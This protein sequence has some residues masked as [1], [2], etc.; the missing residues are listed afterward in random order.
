MFEIKQYKT[1]WD[2]QNP[3]KDEK[4]NR[5]DPGRIHVSHRWPWPS[6]LGSPTNFSDTAGNIQPVSGQIRDGVWNY[7]LVICYIAMENRWPIEIDGYLLKAWWIFPW[8]YQWPGTSDLCF[9]TSK[10]DAVRAN[11]H[12]TVLVCL[13]KR[14]PIFKDWIAKKSNI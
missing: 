2:I 5:W 3:E 10:A 6:L 9:E 8:L 12:R 13:K 14:I 1:D 11:N 4:G 7:P